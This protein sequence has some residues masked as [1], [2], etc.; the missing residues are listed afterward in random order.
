MGENSQVKKRKVMEK[1]IKSSDE[2]SIGYGSAYV[3]SSSKPDRLVGRVLTII[4]ALG[5][6][7]KQENSLKDLLRQEIYNVLELE[8][9]IPGSLNTIIRELYEWREKNPSGCGVDGSENR[10]ER[11]GFLEGDFV[12]NYKE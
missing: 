6:S 7:E 12:L 9:W 2:R 11:F 4:E 8:T 1:T 5:L 3:I 10:H